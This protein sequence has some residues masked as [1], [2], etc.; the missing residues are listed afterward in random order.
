[1]FLISLCSQSPDSRLGARCHQLQLRHDPGSAVGTVQ[2]VLLGTRPYMNVVTCSAAESDYAAPLPW[3]RASL[4][5][6][7]QYAVLL[8]SKTGF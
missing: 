2:S 8:T 6:E 1:M 7:K 5:R 3:Q 4:G